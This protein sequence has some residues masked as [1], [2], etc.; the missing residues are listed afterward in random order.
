MT[1]FRIGMELTNMTLVSVIIITKT[2]NSHRYGLDARLVLETNAP[3]SIPKIP[4]SM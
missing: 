1:H 3:K 2:V 4:M